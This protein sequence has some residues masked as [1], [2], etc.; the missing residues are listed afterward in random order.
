MTKEND[1]ERLSRLFDGDLRGDAPN[2]INREN[3]KIYSIIGDSL[4]DGPHHLSRDISAE[5]RRSLEDTEVKSNKRALWTALIG[6]SLF[7]FFSLNFFVT[8][9]Y[10]I[11]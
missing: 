7:G 3:W 1:N 9:F 10:N 11:S 8:S 2:D 6:G 5:V 4:R